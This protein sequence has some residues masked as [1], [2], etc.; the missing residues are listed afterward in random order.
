MSVRV[1]GCVR[2]PVTTVL[3]PSRRRGLR[4]SVMNVAE[5]RAALS[6]PPSAE[7]A[8]AGRDA[9]EEGELLSF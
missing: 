4:S 1:H 5:Q 7:V 8:T 9:E 6:L 3:Y 2:S